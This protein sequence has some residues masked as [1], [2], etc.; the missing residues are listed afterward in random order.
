MKDG[1][2][3]EADA[4]DEGALNQAAGNEASQNGKLTREQAREK[5]FQELS[6]VGDWPSGMPQED[7]DDPDDDAD[8]EIVPEV[9]K[10]YCAL[11]AEQIDEHKRRMFSGGA[12]EFWNVRQ[13]IAQRIHDAASR[14]SEKYI[15]REEEQLG[16]DEALRRHNIAIWSPHSTTTSSNDSSFTA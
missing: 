16:E 7:D 4:S 10:E 15:A 6:L 11:S 3:D 12:F 1:I 13:L 14:L 2:E 5:L 9:L 8:D